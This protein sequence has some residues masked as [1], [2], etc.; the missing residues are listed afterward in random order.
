MPSFQL[1]FDGQPDEIQPGLILVQ[2]G[3]DRLKR[4]GSQRK[5][6]PLVPKFFSSH[7]HFSVYTLLTTTPI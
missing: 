7:V 3:I 2:R 4:L 5:Q 1:L 6:Y